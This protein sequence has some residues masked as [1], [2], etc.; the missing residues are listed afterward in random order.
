MHSADIIYLQESYL[1]QV[2]VMIKQGDVVKL[3]PAY[4]DPGDDKYTWQAIED[5]DGGR[6]RIMPKDINLRFPP[7][8]VVEVSWLENQ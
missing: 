8:Y 3:K 4:Q 6:V 7:N 1:T 2:T 5:E